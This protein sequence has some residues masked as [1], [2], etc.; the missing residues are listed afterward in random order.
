[1][2][3]KRKMSEGPDQNAWYALRGFTKG[4]YDEMD[5][6]AKKAPSSQLSDLATQ[7]VNR[8]IA[9]SKML[10]ASHDPYVAD[11]SEIVPAGENPE[12]R[13]AVLV[14]REILDAID[15]LDEIFSLDDR[16]GT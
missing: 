15:R 16:R 5:K 12:V 8:S 6:L 2:S 7:R 11:L 1:M 9:E 14:L 3:K 4:L 13:D 10:M